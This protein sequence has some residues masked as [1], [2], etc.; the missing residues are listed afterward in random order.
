MF[1][2]DTNLY[3]RAKDATVTIVT[4]M[5]GFNLKWDMYIK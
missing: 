3:P 2:N 1:K 4:M 5:L